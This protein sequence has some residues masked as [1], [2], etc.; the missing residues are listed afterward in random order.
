MAKDPVAE[1]LEGVKSAEAALHAA[2]EAL[3]QARTALEVAF[4]HK[5][6]S[7]LIGGLDPGAA[8]IYTSPLYPNALTQGQLIAHLQMTAAA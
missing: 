7:R 6:W 4:A 5:G 1:A 2:Q 3:E 8:A